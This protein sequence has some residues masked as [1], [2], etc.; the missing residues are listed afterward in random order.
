MKDIRANSRSY[1]LFSDFDQTLSF[2]DSGNVLS[3]I[4]GVHDFQRSRRGAFQHSPGAAGRRTR[5][6][7]A[8]RSGVPQ[9]A[10]AST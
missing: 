4:L 1:L 10:R 5:L 3:E 9:S 7:S 8:A 2:H 6:S